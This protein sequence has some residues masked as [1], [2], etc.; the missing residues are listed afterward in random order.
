MNQQGATRAGIVSGLCAGCTE[1]E[2][3]ESSIRT[4]FTMIH[5]SLNKFIASGGSADSGS[6]WEQD[7]D[8]MTK[9]PSHNAQAPL[10]TTARRRRISSKRTS[11]RCGRRRS[12]LPAPLNAALWTIFLVASLNWGS[13][14]SF[15][16][17]PRPWS[18]RSGRWWVLQ[19]GHHGEGLQ[20]LEV[21]NLGCCYFWRQFYK[22]KLFSICTSANLFLLQ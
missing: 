14:Q 22:I 9:S 11:R 20:E 13:E 8:C 2:T 12:D 16:T 17:K 19:Q 18:R 3:L 1:N 15:I 4:Q 7:S 21:Q 10:P 6:L 5:G